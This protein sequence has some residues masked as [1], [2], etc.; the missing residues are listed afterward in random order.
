MH[1]GVLVD[2]WIKTV[3]NLIFIFKLQKLQ[4]LNYFII[5]V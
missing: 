3:Y 2:G 4:G 1:A 5:F